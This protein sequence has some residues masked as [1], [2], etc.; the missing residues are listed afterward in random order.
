MIDANIHGRLTRNAEVKFITT[1]RGEQ[2]V[3]KFSIATDRY[4]KKEKIAIFINCDWFS[5]STFMPNTL[6]KGKEVIVRGSLF[7]REYKSKD[8]TMKTS[9]ECAVR[10]VELCGSKSDGEKSEYSPSYA[11]QSPKSNDASGV[12]FDD[13]IGF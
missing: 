10:D 8:G 11:N 13:D 12:D 2:Q 7:P 6:V 9:L 3:I 5:N 1:A 4:E